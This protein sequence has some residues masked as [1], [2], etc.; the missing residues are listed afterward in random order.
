MH[1]NNCIACGGNGS[2]RK[3]GDRHKFR[4]FVAIYHEVWPL[5][6]DHIEYEHGPLRNDSY[7][8][9][10]LKYQVARCPTGLYG[11]KVTGSAESHTELLTSCGRFTKDWQKGRTFASDREADRTVERL[12][13]GLPIFVTRAIAIAAAVGVAGP[14]LV[15][16]VVAVL[17]CC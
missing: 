5:H 8:P 3:W 15:S 4:Y 1:K 9:T 7:L 11:E 12:A 10:G 14:A 6:D 17:S 2:K 16:A 13:S